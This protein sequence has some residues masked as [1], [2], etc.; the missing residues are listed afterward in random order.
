MPALCCE[1]VRR[2]WKYSVDVDIVVTRYRNYKCRNRNS[3]SRAIATSD[4]SGVLK[5]VGR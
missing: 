4:K 5:L 3:N 2:Y 1:N